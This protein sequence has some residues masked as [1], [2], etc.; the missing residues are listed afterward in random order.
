MCPPQQLGRLRQDLLVP[1]WP[2]P[3]SLTPAFA[4]LFLH[5]SERS[6]G[7]WLPGNFRLHHQCRNHNDLIDLHGVLLL[8]SSEQFFG[9]WTHFFQ[10][11]YGRCAFSCL[12]LIPS[13]YKRMIVRTFWPWQPV[14]SAGWLWICLSLASQIFPCAN[15]STLF[16][17]HLSPFSKVFLDIFP[18]LPSTHPWNISSTDTLYVCLHTIYISA[19]A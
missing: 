7:T 9:C 11:H 14:G 5:R 16:R 1:S 2:L 6:F 13:W 8:T 15:F 12:S 19:Y 18:H 4:L 10:G 3:A 17:Y